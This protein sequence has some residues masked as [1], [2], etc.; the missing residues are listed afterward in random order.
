MNFYS[1]VKWTLFHVKPI[2]TKII[3][4]KNKKMVKLSH[5]KYQFYHYL[6]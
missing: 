4:E 2:N 6:N 1:Y 3:S 5:L